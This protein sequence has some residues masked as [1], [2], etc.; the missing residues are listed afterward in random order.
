MAATHLSTKV[1]ATVSA[2]MSEI[3]IASGHR[4]NL[5]IHV[6]KYVNPRDGGKGPDYINMNMVKSS[7]WCEKSTQRY[8]RVTMY[9][10]TLTLDTILVH[11]LTSL[12]IDGQINLCVISF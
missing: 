3:G 6:S 12:F 1:R 2:V 8:H 4:V 7:I 10:S 5:S 9:L 11:D